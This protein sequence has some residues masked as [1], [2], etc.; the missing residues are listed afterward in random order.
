MHSTAYTPGCPPS[1]VF[2]R[3]LSGAGVNVYEQE[4]HAGTMCITLERPAPC[5]SADID[6]D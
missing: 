3:Q 5:P 2:L 1:W 4:M 6:R